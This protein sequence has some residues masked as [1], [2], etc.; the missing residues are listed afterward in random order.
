MSVNGYT[1]CGQKAR[2]TGSCQYNTYGPAGDPRA[3]G[4]GSPA[5]IRYTWSQHR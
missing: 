2:T 1:Y 4:L 5:G 3:A